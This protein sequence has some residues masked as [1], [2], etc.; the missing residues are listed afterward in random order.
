MNILGTSVLTWGFQ[1]YIVLVAA[2]HSHDVT[3]KSLKTENWQKVLKLMILE[4]PY[5]DLLQDLGVKCDNFCHERYFEC[6][7]MKNWPAMIY[8]HFKEMSCFILQR[9]AFD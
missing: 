8:D 5:G 7:I 3:V 4:I 1:W 9:K 6:Q 2:V